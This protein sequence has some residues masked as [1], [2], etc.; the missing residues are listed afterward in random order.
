T[1]PVTVIRDTFGVPHFYASNITDLAFAVGYVQAQDRILQIDLN[2]HLVNGTLAEV[3]G[4]DAVE[5][6]FYHR[7]LGLL[8]WG[9]LAFAQLDPEDHALLQAYCNGYNYFAR[10][11]RLPVDFFFL[12]HTP[13]ELQPRDLIRNGMQ[14]FWS[15]ALNFN[16]E[17]IGL[18]I[19]QKLGPEAL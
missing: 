5:L 17:I 14:A 6:D 18:R 1:A 13:E 19:A 8:R 15:L 16:Q 2:G 11:G 7:V 10:A 12:N 4:E 3:V 9:D